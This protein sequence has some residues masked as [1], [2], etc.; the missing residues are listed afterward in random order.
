MRQ[1]SFFVGILLTS[2]ATSAVAAEI[3]MPDFDT[4]N[5]EAGQP[6]DNAYFPMTDFS[7]TYVY[8]GSYEDDEGETVTESFELTNLASGPE[9]LGVQTTTQLDRSFE[10][11]LLVEETFDY[12]VQDKDGN[13]WYM[14][15]DVTNFVY[16]D[17]DNLI[18]TNDS[19]AWRAGVN[20]ALPGYIMPVTLN[21]GFTYYQE[22]AEADEALDIGTIFSIGEAVSVDFGSF[23]DVLQ[24]LETNPFE[25]D[26]LGFK[27]F[28]PGLGLILEEEGLDE[29]FGDPE[30]TIAL[31]E[32]RSVPEPATLGLL[33]AG[34]ISLRLVQAPTAHLTRRTCPTAGGSG[35]P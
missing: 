9:I 30:L 6:I 33:G 35:V 31:V 3:F 7:H 32:K 5:F 15:E 16:D 12:Y 21:E 18:E 14:G 24:I 23:T 25:P 11:G 27:Y 8:A 26:A 13:V 4:S 34:L 20:D 2:A 28:A 1:R 19:S 10:D 17:D 29:G 22:F